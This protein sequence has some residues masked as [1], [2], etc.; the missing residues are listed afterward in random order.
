MHADTSHATTLDLV[1]SIIVTVLETLVLVRS[2]VHATIVVRLLIQAASALATARRR[3][4]L[5]SL[6]RESVTLTRRPCGACIHPIFMSQA[7]LDA[8]TPG[9]AVD[10]KS[11]TTKLCGNCC[12]QRSEAKNVHLDRSNIHGWGGFLTTAIAKDEFIL[13]YKGEIIDQEDGDEKAFRGALYDQEQLSYMFS[14]N[15]TYLSDSARF[16][17]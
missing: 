9:Y 17:N 1:L 10:N 14:V 6:D 3:H 15:D 12:I 16:G 7:L 8:P 2:T 5:A 11:S 13:E 4:V